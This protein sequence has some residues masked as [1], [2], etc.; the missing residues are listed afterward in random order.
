MPE[1]TSPPAPIADEAVL[2]GMYPPMSELGRLKC[3]DR[4]DKHCRTFIGLSPFV[5]LGTARADGSTDVSPRGDAPGFVRVL[6]DRTLLLPDRPG[7]NRLDS[8][9]NV[10]SNPNVGMLFMIPG[11][12]D[13]LRVNGTAE[14]TTEPALLAGMAV[15]GK[16]PPSAL[17]IAVTECFLHCGKA[18]KRSRL[19]Q[20]DYKI[21]RKTLP[22]LGT[23]IVEQ[24][25]ARIDPAE[26]DARVEEGYR[27]KMY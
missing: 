26:A 19:W 2:R 14:L 25:R 3:L 27:T 7:N 12:D 8:L 15:Q 24:T 21:E 22:G 5:A 17:K 4:L 20:D 9:S 10:L 6:D 11:V 23:M 16:L 18:L 13:T 1:D